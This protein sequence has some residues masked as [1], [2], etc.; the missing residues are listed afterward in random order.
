MV[1]EICRKAGIS[2]ATYFNWK[3]KDE[4]LM[5]SEILQ[6]GTAPQRD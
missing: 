5:P 3:K 4:S 1:G 6:R 2:S